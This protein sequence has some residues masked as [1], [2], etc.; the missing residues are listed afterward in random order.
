M[1]LTSHPPPPFR[2]L[3]GHKSPYR[4]GQFSLFHRLSRQLL[5]CG[6]NVFSPARRHL[7]RP[8]RKSGRPP[9]SPLHGQYGARASFSFV[10][11]CL[12]ACAL[13]LPAL[14][15]A[16]ASAQL[17][18]Q[19]DL[20]PDRVN[21]GG[22]VDVV[23]C[24]TLEPTGD[25]PADDVEGT[26]AYGISATFRLRGESDRGGEAFSDVI[27]IDA[28]QT[29]STETVR[30]GPLPAGIW[31]FSLANVDETP[32]GSGITLSA[33]PR[34]VS[35]TPVTQV[36]LEVLQ[37]EVAAGE[38]VRLRLVPDGV[39]NRAREFVVRGSSHLG[40]EADPLTVQISADDWIVERSFMDLPAGLWSFFLTE[41]LVGGNTETV[42]VL[43]MPQVR[44]GFPAITVEGPEVPGVFSSDDISYASL[45]DSVVLRVSTSTPP[46]QLVTFMLRGE[47]SSGEFTDVQSVALNPSGSPGTVSFNVPGEGLWAFSIAQ[48]APAN[49]AD[50]AVLSALALVRVGLPP[51]RLSGF[52]SWGTGE[53]VQLRLSS[54]LAVTGEFMVEGVK[55]D[56]S[57]RNLVSFT[58]ETQKDINFGR[59]TGGQW[60]FR[61]IDSSPTG[62]ADISRAQ[63]EVLVE[64]G[65]EFTV[66]F[67]PEHADTV[68]YDSTRSRYFVLEDSD[69]RALF[70]TPN[71]APDLNPG[72]GFCQPDIFIRIQGLTGLGGL[73]EIAFQAFHGIGERIAGIGSNVI[74]AGRTNEYGF[75]VTFAAAERY[76]FSISS[77]VSTVDDIRTVYVEAPPA[78]ESF[79][80]GQD[81]IEIG[82]TAVLNLRLRRS[83]VVDSRFTVRAQDISAAGSSAR[84]NTIVL[85]RGESSAAVSFRNME[86]GVWRFTLVQASPPQLQTPELLATVPARVVAGRLAV[87]IEAPA[88]VAGEEVV[89]RLVP[90]FLLQT[91]TTFTVTA[92]G[93]TAG[94]LMLASMMQQV[95]LPADT[96]SA[97][98]A[99]SGL[100]PGSWVFSITG[101]EPENAELDLS[102]T[103]AVRVGGLRAELRAADLDGR[104]QAGRDVVLLLELPQVLDGDIVFTVRAEGPGGS[105]VAQL[106]LRSGVS[107]VSA[108]FSG[109]EPG[110]WQFT[111]SA[112][113]EAI[114]TEG[115]MVTL[116]VVSRSA[117]SLR[118]QGARNVA[119]IG[120]VLPS[121]LAVQ[122][123]I[124]ATPAAI[125]NAVLTLRAVS[126]ATSQMITA[127]LLADTATVTVDFGVLP[128]GVWRFSVAETVPGDLFDAAAEVEVGDP[129]AAGCAERGAH[130]RARQLQPAFDSGL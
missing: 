100:S 21:A 1:Q 80:P 89:L 12:Y 73:E 82:D 20:S 94:G 27:E 72:S 71:G 29:T 50:S 58:Q 78:V 5:H 60:S 76:V 49:T 2:P 96:L 6:L 34:L 112:S 119:G 16:P 51:L 48:Q 47:S 41:N 32:L 22:R 33:P 14:A 57:M 127:T 64:D 122:L 46:R 53:N 59:L 10:R 40:A 3:P 105:R 62:V 37:S 111:V 97:E 113:V 35:F 26:A 24:L 98:A 42:P 117:L 90:D 8:H 17:A 79:S 45:S 38:A 43:G 4:T 70:R 39:Y 95:H 102:S 124:T 23:L 115:V 106:N 9:S 86:R 63:R 118:V 108:V 103:A 123:R 15:A 28:Q 101:V 36:R 11:A 67:Q 75:D 18:L 61:V 19:L 85:L 68:R 83:A 130:Y 56:S 66:R 55:G 120:N 93:R 104:V 81:V 121:D 69:A 91:N 31:S 92:A 129:Q 65:M 125:D 52:D 128:D 7:G 109:L 25:C 110:S 30:L 77:F 126:G 13:L 107:A 114:D 84:F 116:D 99:F 74:C 44:V 88:S 87:R 54:P